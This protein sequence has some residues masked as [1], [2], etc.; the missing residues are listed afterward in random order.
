[1][2]QSAEAAGL[3]ARLNMR[4]RWKLFIDKAANT[5]AEAEG[6]LAAAKIAAIDSE[7]KS[8]FRSIMNVHDVVPDLK[9][10][11]G[12]EDLFVQLS[13]FHG[14]PAASARALLSESYVNALAISVYLAAALKHAG[15]PRF[16]VLD[17]VT[18]SFD[19]GHQLALM[20]VIRQKLQQPSNPSGLQFF[21]LS[22]DG[23]LEKYFDRLGN[24]GSWKHHRLQGSPPMGQVLG[25]F[26]DANRLRAN[27]VA[28]LTAGQISQ[29]EPLIR[30]YLEFKLTQIIRKVGV[31]VPIDFAMKETNRMVSNCLD[32]ITGAIDLHKRAGTLVLDANQVQQLSTAHVPALLGN[33]CSHYETAA[34]TSISGPMLLS[35]LQSIDDLSECFRYNDTA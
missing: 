3:A 23:L 9:R 15:A 30:Q 2:L 6:A 1:L 32:A 14:Q 24:D 35:V 12:S 7:Y 17:D 8:T 13:D 31:P 5:F 21:I 26:Q 20:E 25:Q 16:L 22:H 19:A 18:S 11:G 33:W 4:T 29:A 27:L 34:A 28:L 10:A